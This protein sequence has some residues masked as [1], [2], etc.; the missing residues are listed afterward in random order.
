MLTSAG[1]SVEEQARPHLTLPEVV[2]K[3]LEK[4]AERTQALENYSNKRIYELD[5]RGFPAG[6]HAEMVVRMDYHAPG[7]KEFQILSESGPKWIVN[8]VL[9]RL[10]ETE[11]EAQ[12]PE[13]RAKVE[14]NTRNY[15]FTSLEY[16]ATTDGCTYVL[17]VEPKVP[18][19]FL[20]RGRIWI[21]E[22]DFA[23]CRIEGEPAQNPSEWITKT[24]IR[25]TYQK[26][27]AFWL[28]AENQS[29]STLRLNGHASLN[30]KYSD[31]EVNKPAAAQKD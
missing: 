5:Y 12:K 6:F 17:N 31:Y 3:L 25:H 16:R 22:D 24:E 26:L 10:I 28:P 21:N 29:D 15:G 7:K 1:E 27:G 14:L 23:V 13:N 4:N 20:Y 18:N 2:E 9:K 19:K 11:R 8:R 30:I